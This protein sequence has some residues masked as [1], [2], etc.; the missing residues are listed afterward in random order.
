MAHSHGL[1]R[2]AVV[3]VAVSWASLGIAQAATV[4]YN[5]GLGT[6][7]EAQGWTKYEGGA[8]VP[9]P[10]VSGGLLHQGPTDTGGHQYWE[11]NAASYNFSTGTVTVDF[12]L[13]ITSSSFHPY[14]R[15]GYTVVLSDVNGRMASLYLAGSSVF[16]GNDPVSGGSAIIPFD[17]TDGFHDYQLTI[18][19]AGSALSI[20]STPIVSL[21]L[22]GIVFPANQIYF[23]DGT[24]LAGS[25]SDLAYFT[26]SG[27]TLANIPEP[28]SAGLFAAGLVAMAAVRRRS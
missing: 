26:V 23:G 20:D 16:L 3:G 11:Y 22:G 13:R 6:L 7:P 17:T 24:V 4:T 25:E 28:F 10:F 5:P 27:V 15:G 14:P 8:V 19:P 18:G 21:A 12:R 1:V 9:A 2:L